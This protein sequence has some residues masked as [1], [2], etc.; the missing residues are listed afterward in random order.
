M[1]PPD[2]NKLFAM[3]ASLLNEQNCIVISRKD[4]LSCKKTRAGALL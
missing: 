4:N 2:K 1:I 3:K